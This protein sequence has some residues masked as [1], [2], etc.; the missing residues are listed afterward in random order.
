MDNI[1]ACF[2]ELDEEIRKHP[3]F[4]G[5]IEQAYKEMLRTVES[6]SLEFAR[7]VHAFLFWTA[8]HP[9]EALSQFVNR[10]KRIDV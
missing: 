1:G 9:D 10:W 2:E 6:S 7:L 5:E 8:L 3:R 4:S